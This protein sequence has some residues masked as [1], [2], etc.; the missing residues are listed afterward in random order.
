MVSSVESNAHTSEVILT[1]VSGMEVYGDDPRTELDSHSNMVVLWSN[2]FV[3]ESTGS[4]WNIQPL[5]N[6][7]DM[8]RNVPIVDGALNIKN[9]AIW[10]VFYWNK[11]VLI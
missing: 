3:F 7:I 8:E 11:Q 6:D 2:S 1:P 4:T 9:H 10:R 5:N